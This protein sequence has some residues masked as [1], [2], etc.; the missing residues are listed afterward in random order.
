MR[1]LVKT[2]GKRFVP[3]ISDWFDNFWSADRFFHDDFFP[4]RNDFMPSVN[5]MENDKFFEIEVAAPGLHKE[6]FDVRI[7]NGLLTISVEREETKE[8]KDANYTRKEFSYNTF[9]RTFTLPENVL[10]EKI[11]AK[12]V[13]GVLKLM[14]KKTAVTAPKAKKIAI[15]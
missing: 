2:N 3:R 4:I 9:R 10:E 6:D 8:E 11:E 15:S 7:E 13:N 14:L 1:S 5:I 12:Y